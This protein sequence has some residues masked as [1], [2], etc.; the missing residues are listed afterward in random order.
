MTTNYRNTGEIVEFAATLVAGD[1]FM[2]IEGG[3]GTADAT[4][5]ILQRG[6]RPTIERFTTPLQ[7]DT[8]LVKHVRSLVGGSVSLGDI[9]ILSMTKWQL[10]AVIKTLTAAGIP[11]DRPREVRPSPD[12][13][14]QSRNSSPRQGSRVQAGLG[15][16]NIPSAT[17]C[18]DHRH[19]GRPARAP[20]PRPPSPVC[21]DD[22]GPGWAVG[23]GGLVPQPTQQAFEALPRLGSTVRAMAQ[24]AA[25]GASGNGLPDSE[26]LRRG[27]AGAC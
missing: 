21:R 24:Q 27:A 7:H 22:A 14:S 13:R 8:S 10:A 6:P 19:R 11:R 12:E 4:G 18:G 16:T 1:E 9:G 15:G 5:E 25:R 3:A 2:D 26:T 17:G 23:W 20:R